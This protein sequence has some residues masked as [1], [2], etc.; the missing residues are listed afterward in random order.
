MYIKVTKEDINFYRFLLV[1]F[2]C[3][4]CILLYNTRLLQDLGSSKRNSDL[5]RL[6]EGSRDISFL[7]FYNVLQ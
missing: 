6:L 3:T 1:F 7:I 2:T 5:F 4:A